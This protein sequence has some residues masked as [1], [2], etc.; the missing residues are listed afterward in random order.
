MAPVLAQRSYSE[1]RPRPQ[2]ST[3]TPAVPQGAVVAWGRDDQGQD[4]VP[5][6]ARSGVRALSEGSLHSLA[7][8]SDG[9]VVAWGSNLFGQ[10][11][12]PLGLTGIVAVA[13]GANHSLALKSD[14]TLA[15]WGD[16]HSGQVDVPQGLAGIVAVAA[17]ANHNL[18]LKSDGTVTAWGSNQSGQL[19][20][21][22]GLAGIVAVAAGAYHSL[23]LRGDGTVVAWGGN[24]EGQSTVP[25][26]L[27]RVTA[28]AAGAAHSL[29]LRSDGTVVAWGANDAGQATV[30]PELSGVAAVA[31][32]GFHS[33]ALKR[34][35][36][37]VAW[38]ENSDGQATV[39]TGLAGVSSLAAGAS[40]SLV[41]STAPFINGPS[42]Q[43]T[44][45]DVATN[46]I[47]FSIG[48]PDSPLAGL[49]INASSSE[50]GLVKTFLFTGNGAT[51]TI[52]VT[53]MPNA[54]GTSTI[55]ITVS[56]GTSTATAT[57]QFT[58]QPV[59]DAPIFMVG[60]NPTVM[61]DS[62]PQSL[63][64][65][66]TVQAGPTEDEFDQNLEFQVTGN[67]NP[68]L[69]ASAPVIN[70]SNG[71]LT[72]TPTAEAHGSAIIT[73]L[74]RDD[75]GTA[76]GGV[77]TSGTQSYTITVAPGNDEPSADAQTLTAVEDTASPVT[78]SG[79]DPDGDALTYSVVTGP[80][81][82]T[83]SGT[84]PDLTYTPAAN[85]NGPDSFTF[86]AND[87]TVDS[88]PATI[89][90][91]VMPVNDAPVAAADT[92]AVGYGALLQVAAPGVRANDMD[93]D[94]DTLTAILENGPA[95]GSL[96]LNGDGSF[97]YQ[98]VVGYVGEDSFTYRVGDGAAESVPAT[99]TLTV[100]AIP[101]S[102]ANAKVTGN[103]TVLID[104]MKVRFTV[105]AAFKR[106][107][108]GNLTFADRTPARK[109]KK[110]KILAV[111]VNGRHARVYGTAT[112]GDRTTT[113][114][115]ADLDDPAAG[116]GSDRFGLE[117][118]NGQSVP[119]AVV[120]GK[121][122]IKP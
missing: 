118:G 103:G 42:D 99:V 13:A 73:L 121:V 44:R 49:G 95:H 105:S 26:G 58:V 29:A 80:A 110:A 66:A 119:S 6:R 67:S 63:V 111:V 75:G 64:G 23:A 114:F 4:T 109:V 56:D 47:F 101:A 53:P 18:T 8:K 14:G 45:E 92:Y 3:R 85:Y 93:A 21:P 98:P 17:G 48:D 39:P 41:I 94:G 84:A 59:N 36:T 89:S 10:A 19:D 112:L 78:L 68:G 37:V 120:K 71:N 15:A 65:W 116:G 115:V 20:A 1:R 5:L 60:G 54:N 38:G 40:R 24:F 30:P 108:T 122:T 88:S 107:V 50:P 69:F 96:T 74:L 82:G 117:L 16:N 87:G 33:L 27:G 81:H 90:L 28:V 51:R 86:V 113:P 11:E 31:A 70:P 55:T 32:G 2:G 9:T 83:L 102:T 25:V 57:F 97:T 76:N 52:R 35:G 62:G 43:V 77:D 34:D 79:S 61:E 91:S 22:E 104:G 72:F 100:G 46:D 7:L 106:K 12:V